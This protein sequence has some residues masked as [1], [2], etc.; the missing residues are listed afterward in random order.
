MAVF[1]TFIKPDSGGSFAH[2]QSRVAF[3]DQLPTGRC[4]GYTHLEVDDVAEA[5]LF[6]GF[7]GKIST[8][9]PTGFLRPSQEPID[10][11]ASAS[12]M[13]T[14]YLEP[15]TSKTDA[16]WQALASVITQR[17]GVFDA[18][19]SATSIGYL[20]YRNVD[21]A[22]AKA[23]LCHRIK[24]R[25]PQTAGGCSDKAWDRFLA[26]DGQIPVQAG[27]RIGAAGASYLPSTPANR[28]QVAVGVRTHFGMFDLGTFYSTMTGTAG[29]QSPPAAASLATRLGVR[30]QLID[31][32]RA[33]DAV[34]DDR[35]W[36][37][38]ALVDYKRARDLKYSEWRQLGNR[39][40]AK[41]RAQLLA[42]VRPA[43]APPNTARFDFDVDDMSN[44]FQLEAVVEFYMNL[45]EPWDV[46][47]APIAPGA[48]D[49]RA[50]NLLALYGTAAQINGQ[51]VTLDDALDMIRVSVGRDTLLLE[52]EGT[53]PGKQF[54]IMDVPGG[55][56][57]TVDAA[58]QIGGGTSAWRIFDSPTLIHIDSFG[59]RLHGANAVSASA[60]AIELQG[61][62]DLQ[63]QALAQVNPYE[64]IALGTATA[65]SGAARIQQVPVIDRTARTARLAVDR[66]VA[67]PA[68]GAA[69]TIPAGVGGVQGFLSKKPKNPASNQWG[70]DHYDGMLFLV[71]GGEVRCAFPWTSYTSRKLDH[72]GRGTRFHSSIKGNRHYRFATIFS[73]NL[74]INVAFSVIDPEG[75][76]RGRRQTPRPPDNGRPG[77]AP[78]ETLATLVGKYQNIY[79]IQA[80][81]P[82]FSVGS[83]HSVDRTNNTLRVHKSTAA[84][85]PASPTPYW[86]LVYDGA[87]GARFYF[88]PT[89]DDDTAPPDTAVPFGPNELGKGGIRIHHGG[90]GTN[91]SQG[92]Q[93]SPYFMRLRMALIDYHKEVN[94][95][96][97]D[98]NA[99]NPALDRV[100]DMH[101]EDNKPPLIVEYEKLTKDLAALQQQ[102][103]VAMVDPIA[104]A[105]DE[106]VRSGQDD[107][108]RLLALQEAINETRAKIDFA[109][110]VADTPSEDQLIPV[111]ETL[112]DLALDEDVTSMVEW[113]KQHQEQV[114][115]LKQQVTELDQRLKDET[116]KWGWNDAMQ[117]DY[118]LVRPDERVV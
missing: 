9:A 67:L 35:L 3:G 29:V 4:S 103:Q 88:K 38:S 31:P 14:L 81:P 23:A 85:V 75:V 78:V 73:R 76:P 84:A 30:A 22:E 33:V 90:F 118:W 79:F 57:V 96:Y 107:T 56:R 58:P 25:P 87:R 53:R 43:S 94:R 102:L 100:R 27:D 20:V 39:Q 97:Y 51:D 37:W 65:S 108:S 62:S 46:G 41:Y 40:K 110:D 86:L 55:Q 13:L 98:E 1:D 99:A 116:K 26:G 36:P 32:S 93:V 70:W 10:S 17:Y 106:V 111:L 16:Q 19:F 8:T 48:A 50:I 92:C 61:L 80:A 82:R 104:R 63:I 47:M 66:P 115:R 64:T 83:I 71:G 59:A 5:G 11:E 101:S 109:Q 60:Q 113:A 95:T 54:R 21:V 28:R 68:G 42:R 44:L 72:K 52:S 18:A 74:Y 49:Y 12:T 2:W 45:T 105:V 24:T 114:G 77:I 91:G 15:T 34:G 6:A 112:T 117:G 69:W 89:F 7:A